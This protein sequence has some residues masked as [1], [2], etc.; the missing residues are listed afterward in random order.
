[1]AE[2]RDNPKVKCDSLASS[3]T[4]ATP[5][6]IENVKSD[7]RNSSLQRTLPSIPGCVKESDSGQIGPIYDSPPPRHAGSGEHV[8]LVESRYEGASEFCAHRV[9]DDGAD[10]KALTYVEKEEPHRRLCPGKELANCCRGLK[11]TA[12]S[13]QSVNGNSTEQ[14]PPQ[15]RNTWPATA[16]E[17]IYMNADRDLASLSCSDA[18]YIQIND[19]DGANGSQ[20]DLNESDD[21]PEAVVNNNK[22]GDTANCE[23]ISLGDDYVQ[24]DF[25][26]K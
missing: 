9:D 26:L 10:A 3:L 20:T 5:V 2:P 7:V 18:T 24:T 16:P 14:H 19:S 17:D 15:E 13:T 12:G 21:E 25:N 11:P 23:N 1:M 8:C 22:R 6:T 4:S